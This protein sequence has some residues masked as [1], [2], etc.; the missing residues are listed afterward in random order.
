MKNSQR[1]L[2]GS[3]GSPL[4]RPEGGLVSD[5][6]RVGR[7]ADRFA[8]LEPC[9]EAA[10][11]RRE[12]GGEPGECQVVARGHAV[13]D[14]GREHAR[15]DDQLGGGEDQH[16]EREVEARDPDRHRQTR[17]Q[18]E[19]HDLLADAPVGGALPEAV[20]PHHRGAVPAIEAAHMSASRHQPIASERRQTSELTTL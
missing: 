6:A 16:E 17:R 3:T 20:G 13:A 9:A 8:R 14:G 7:L 4:P 10:R 19:E 2:S 1:R 11:H 15:P 18:V 5:R 12:G